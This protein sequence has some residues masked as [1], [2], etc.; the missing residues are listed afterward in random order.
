MPGLSRSARSATTPVYAA[1]AS[2]ALA[3][4]EPST[5]DSA[6][7]RRLLGLVDD[8][9][10]FAVTVDEADDELGNLREVGPR[11]DDL[12]AGLLTSAVALEQ[13]HA[14]TSTARVAARRPSRR[15]RA[16]RAPAATTAASIFPAPTRR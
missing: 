3:L 11:A 6:E 15:W 1:T 4:R 16:G 5:V 14:G 7:G 13:W 2:F 12:Q 10:Y 8:V 9:P